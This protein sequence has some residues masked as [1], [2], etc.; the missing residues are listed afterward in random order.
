MAL[1][2]G[3][4]AF[5]SGEASGTYYIPEDIYGLSTYITVSAA[6][7]YKTATITA[8]G[9]TTEVTYFYVQQKGENKT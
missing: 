7:G 1:M 5:A 8:D 3:M 4:G 6:E 2:L 9:K